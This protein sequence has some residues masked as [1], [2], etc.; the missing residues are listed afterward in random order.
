MDITVIQQIMA[1]KLINSSGSNDI[2]DSIDSCGISGSSVIN[3]KN[4]RTNIS[5]ST[6]I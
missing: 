2:S 1:V 4:N 3:D 6:D 5:D